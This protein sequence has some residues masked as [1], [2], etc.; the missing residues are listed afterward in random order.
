MDT[1]DDSE[2]DGTPVLWMDDPEGP[3][4]AEE[5]YLLRQAVERCNTLEDSKVWSTICKSIPGR[6]NKQCRER[7]EEHLKPGI[8]KGYGCLFWS[9]SE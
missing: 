4:T 5:D 6:T 2:N 8:N 3:W 7:W 1:A 9:A